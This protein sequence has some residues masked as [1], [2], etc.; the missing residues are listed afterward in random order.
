MADRVTVD[1]LNGASS[2]ALTKAAPATNAVSLKDAMAAFA[3]VD[4]AATF[5]GD[6]GSDTVHLYL[7]VSH[8]G[9]ETWQ[10]AGREVTQ[11][12]PAGSPYTR[13]FFATDTPS[14]SN[15]VSAAA[16]GSAGL[17]DYNRTVGHVRLKADI[18]DDDSDAV[19]T[20]TRASLTR[21][22]KWRRGVR[23]R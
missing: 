14:P 8:D 15:A 23:M 7:Q 13:S 3:A 2:V 11:L 19:L 22:Y 5:S 10:D 16:D 18:G 4:F 9:G 20:L 12:T 21:Y 1:L 17:T 6:A